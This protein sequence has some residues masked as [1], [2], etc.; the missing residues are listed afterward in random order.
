MSGLCSHLKQLHNLVHTWANSTSHT[1]YNVVKL[2]MEMLF[3]KDTSWD[4]IWMP[5]LAMKGIGWMQS[6]VSS[7][8]RLL[9]TFL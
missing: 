8:E 4:H 7:G 9:F 6:Q 2:P 1:G 5:Q 3:K